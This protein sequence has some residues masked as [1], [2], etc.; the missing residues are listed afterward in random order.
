MESSTVQVSRQGPAWVIELR[1]EHDIST[2]AALVD[3]LGRVDGAGAPQVVVDLSA[4]EFIDSSVLAALAHG[5]EHVDAAGGRI[6]I[7]AP[8]AG[9][10]R[11]LLRLVG[12]ERPPLRIVETR[13]E[14]LRSLTAG[15]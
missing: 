12:L 7:V 4:A 3:A 1:G 5:G 2:S 10:A 14:A 6:A 11:R 13:V 8:S 15:G 9:R